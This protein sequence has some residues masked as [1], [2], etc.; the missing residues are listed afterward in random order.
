MSSKPKA[1]TSSATAIAAEVRKWILDGCRWKN[2]AYYNDPL[3][4]LCQGDKLLSYQ[5][6]FIDVLDCVFARGSYKH[7]RPVG[8]Y[9]QSHSDAS[10]SR[11]IYSPISPESIPLQITKKYASNARGRELARNEWEYEKICR[12]STISSPSTQSP[13]DQHT[14]TDTR[15][16]P[17]NNTQSDSNTNS[18]KAE[19]G[20]AVDIN[21]MT[22]ECAFS[23]IQIWLSQIIHDSDLQSERI[24]LS[25]LH[26]VA[27]LPRSDHNNPAFIQA[28]RNLIILPHTSSIPTTATTPT[29]PTIESIMKN[30]FVLLIT[31]DLVQDLR[32]NWGCRDLHRLRLPLRYTIADGRVWEN[33][34]FPVII[35][36]IPYLPFSRGSLAGIVAL[37][38]VVCYHVIAPSHA[39]ATTLCTELVKRINTHALGFESA[40]RAI[41]AALTRWAFEQNRPAKVSERSISSY[42]RSDD[43]HDLD[44][45]KEIVL[46]LLVRF[47]A[48]LLE[49]H[50]PSSPDL[51]SPRRVVTVPTESRKR[52]RCDDDDDEKEENMSDEFDDDGQLDYTRKCSRHIQSGGD[53]R[54]GSGHQSQS[55][56]DAGKEDSVAMTELFTQHS[57]HRAAQEAQAALLLSHVVSSTSVSAASLTGAGTE[58]GLGTETV[59]TCAGPQRD[60]E[61]LNACIAII[62]RVLQKRMEDARL[63]LFPPPGNKE[64]G[65]Q[66][67]DEDEEKEEEGYIDMIADMLTDLQALDLA[68]GLRDKDVVA[69]A[70]EKT[71]ARL[72]SMSMELV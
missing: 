33:M 6:V 8:R 40:L 69:A 1:T 50:F 4:A 5:Y 52:G 37:A 42:L 41:R 22:R 31:R 57:L 67:E 19:T 11:N 68:G 71:S 49:M 72:Q 55:R 39:L 35:A 47:R 48:S 25:I 38:E 16:T 24:A 12:G 70:I 15:L 28:M 20:E 56:V 60:L 17:H 61:L 26:K 45:P 43:E 3:E 46:P 51:L 44:E 63:G 23:F 13:G 64:E 29:T 53:V 59:R 14:T 62:E 21:L 7:L 27:Q 9:K 2:N 54:G 66:D 36:S 34:F 32:Y 10:F 18:C 58:S 65:K 30:L